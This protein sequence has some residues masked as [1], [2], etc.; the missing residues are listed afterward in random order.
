MI[1]TRIVHLD[2]MLNGARGGLGIG[3]ERNRSNGKTAV[4]MGRG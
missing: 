1:A 4:S 2:P 3:M